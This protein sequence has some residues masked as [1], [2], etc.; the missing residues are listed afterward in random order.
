MNND[1]ARSH[2]RPGQ[3]RSRLGQLA[4][5]S[6]VFLL[7]AASCD[8]LIA[9]YNVK[10]Y[11]N[12]TS[13][14]A[15]ASIVM[16]KATEPFSDHEAAVEKLMLGVEQAYE[17]VNGIPKNSNSAAQWR[18]LKDPNGQLLGGF[19]KRWEDEDK[20]SAAFVKNHWDDNV[21]PAFDEIIK[22]ENGK[23]RNGNK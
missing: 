19:M 12:A 6:V 4:L 3:S 23:L 8:P 22:L 17:Y 21:G 14:K 15:E 5:L 10:A 20:L 16:K 1:V 18:I 7:A 11:E 2:H 13:L 9:T